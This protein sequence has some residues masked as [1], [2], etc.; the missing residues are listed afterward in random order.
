YTPDIYAQINSGYLWERVEGNTATGKFTEPRP[1]YVNNRQLGS[2]AAN[3]HSGNTYYADDQIY[4]LNADPDEDNNL[5]GQDPAAAY[6]LKK[7]LANYIGAIPGRP[8]RQF[9]DSSTEFSPAPES[10]PMLPSSV[11]MSFLGLNQVEL[12]WT[13]AADSELGYVVRKIVNGG[14]PTIV[15]EYP[16]GTKRAVVDLDP[17]AE[18]ILIEV[19]SYNALGDSVVNQDLLSP[20]QWRFRTFGASDP[21]LSAP[22]S[23]WENDADG[24]GV[25]TM[26]EYAAGTDP[27]S[28]A[29]VAKP[30]MRMASEADNRFLEYVLP[31]SSRRAVEFRGA[32]STDLTTW[33]SGDQHCNVI[34]EGASQ[35]IFRSATPLGDAPRQFIRAEMVSP[36]VDQP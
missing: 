24:D 19:A 21:T 28:A 4:D 27:L 34:E 25:S 12:N 31:R 20:E 18:D 11:Q 9:S 30:E 22:D 5:Y 14:T 2:L 3:S 23:Q 36:P 13:D 6:D 15:G 29:S 17:D 33:F 1:Y 35:M 16:A 8:F 32:V 10:A 26:W 7:R